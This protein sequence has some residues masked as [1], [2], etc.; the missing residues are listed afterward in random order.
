MLMAASG[1]AN[2]SRQKASAA[3]SYPLDSQNADLVYVQLFLSQFNTSNTDSLRKS[4]LRSLSAHAT[5]HYPNSSYG[6]YPTEND[7][8]IAV[9]LVA[10][11]YSPNNFWFVMSRRK[12]TYVSTHR[13]Y[14]GTAATAQPINSPSHPPLQPSA[15]TFTS[16]Y[17]TTKMVTLR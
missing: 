13:R 15:V 12:S 5:E 1:R 8:A 17:T 2:D 6:V 4:L 11:R 14:T 7:S 3:Q 16:M 10:N 9:V